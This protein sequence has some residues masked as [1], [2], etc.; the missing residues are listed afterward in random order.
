M[1]LGIA[2][3]HRPDAEIRADIQAEADRLNHC[4]TVDDCQQVPLL[5]DSLVTGNAGDHQL[6]D[7]L[8]RELRDAHGSTACQTSCACGLLGC[9]S[10]RCVALPG[11][12][13]TVPAGKKMICL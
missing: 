2:A 13:M 4:S 6:L 10:S 8:T 11:D 7:A 12:C 1:L 9:E 3:C 5:C